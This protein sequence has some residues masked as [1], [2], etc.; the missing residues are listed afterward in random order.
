LLQKTLTAPAGCVADLAYT[1]AVALAVA[2]AAMLT[3]FVLNH[4]SLGRGGQERI[5]E[6]FAAGELIGRDFL[7]GDTRLG[8]HQYNDCLILGMAAEQRHS[9]AKLAVSPSIPFMVGKSVCEE[10]K[11]NRRSGEPYY[12]HN[13]IHG[14]TMLARYLLPVCGVEGMRALYKMALSLV[15]LATIAVCLLRLTVGDFRPTV[16]LVPLAGFLRLFGLE[17][18]GQS[19]SHGPSDLV[20]VSFVAFL[21]FRAGELTRA[22]LVAA[23]AIFGALTMIFEFMTGGLPLGLA[24]IVG[25]SW[26]ALRSPSVRDCLAAALA[27]L[28]AAVGSLAIK[29]AA[30]AYVFGG[31]ALLGIGQAAAHRVSGQIEVPGIEDRSLLQAVVGNLGALTPGMDAA[32][33]ILVLLAV[34]F[35]AWALVQ[36][37][38]P[39]I[40]LLAFSN[41]PIIGWLLFFQQHTIVH[42][43]FMDRM[44]VWPII[45]GCLMFGLVIS[46]RR[47]LAAAAQ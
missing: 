30:V 24:A 14:H 19:L 12:Y 5:A 36:N 34:G 7:P 32:A 10:L 17:T 43:W 27:F 11:S 46:S 26:F 31:A 4:A 35:G 1:A 8:V 9:A 29:L 3:F 15:L 16:F 2:L 13:Y 18:F 28:V 42:A 47:D 38:T 45:S 40:G 41:L 25:L 44:L 6:A 21:T 22:G 23:A 39:K 33:G 37:S 20:L